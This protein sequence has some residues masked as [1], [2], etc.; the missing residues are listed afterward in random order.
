MP[1]EAEPAVPRRRSVV[2]AR[3]IDLESPILTNTHSYAVQFQRAGWDARWLCKPATIG[4]C[5]RTAAQKGECYGIR[6]FRLSFLFNYGGKAF[7]RHKVFWDAFPFFPL[8]PGFRGMRRAGLMN[9]EVFFIGSL[10][11]ASLYKL[12]RPKAVVYNAHDAF[13]LYPNAPAS[14][15]QIEAAVV[16]R[17]DL[18]V[19]TAETT[20]ELLMS[21]YGIAPERIVNL[22]HGVDNQRF[23]RCSE[24]ERLKGIA[25]PRVVCLGTLDMQD[26]DLTMRAAPAPRGRASFSSAQGGSAA[27]WLGSRWRQEQPLFG[28]GL[29]G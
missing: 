8:S 18:I 12:F 19:T 4:N 17:A 25:R 10:E 15:R 27:G 22:G 1:P 29:P 21:Q 9:P 13:S 5:F 11:T 26:A 2:F 6:Q 23:A 28:A 16:K 14:I 20:R 24:P 3:N 7:N